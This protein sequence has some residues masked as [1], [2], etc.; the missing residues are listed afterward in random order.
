MADFP[1]AD[2]EFERIKEGL[3]SASPARKGEL[4]DDLVLRYL[5]RVQQYAH[6]AFFDQLRPM[7]TTLDVV[8]RVCEKLR[9]YVDQSRIE[10]RTEEE[11]LALLDRMTRQVMSDMARKAG[12][13]R[14]VSLDDC[15]IDAQGR[16][17]REPEDEGPSPSEHAQGREKEA[18][19]AFLGEL[20]RKHL[21]PD[22]AY[23]IVRH[24]LEGVSYDDLA[25]EPQERAGR[26]RDAAALRSA[27][28][29]IRKGLRDNPA[30]NEDLRRRGLLSEGE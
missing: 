25:R 27:A 3:S 21:P 29:R 7:V 16:A 14:P 13:P 11:L 30:I 4:L 5:P 23:L 9:R 22:E 6:R 17:P 19:L 18:Q 1:G 26:A 24:D 28:N 12:R 10:L 2:G 8:S 15:G 20:L